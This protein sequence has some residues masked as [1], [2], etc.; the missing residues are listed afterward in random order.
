MHL[1][2]E[3]ISESTTVSKMLQF[4]VLITLRNGTIK[5]GHHINYFIIFVCSLSTLQ[6]HVILCSHT[7]SIYSFHSLIRMNLWNAYL[8]FKVLS[9]TVVSACVIT[10]CFYCRREKLSLCCSV[11]KIT[12]E[13]LS[14]CNISGAQN[15][16][17]KNE[18][19]SSA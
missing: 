18:L 1:V 8:R 17:L 6:P 13:F 16:F 11:K 5:L 12:S 9:I 2:K 14:F 7:L 10:L 19:F 3:N 15:Y 4:K